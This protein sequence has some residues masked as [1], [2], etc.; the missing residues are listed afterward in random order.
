MPVASEVV[1]KLAVPFARDAVPSEVAPSINEIPPV[2][3]FPDCAV[4]PTLKVRLLPAV[5]W[6]AEAASVVVV[7]IKIGCTTNSTAE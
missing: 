7:E 6:G 2:G 3:A 5:I 4:T 1:D